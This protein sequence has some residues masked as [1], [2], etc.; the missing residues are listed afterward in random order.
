[1]TC[2]TFL[3]C[4]KHLL[5]WS[6]QL[7]QLTKEVP[8]SLCRVLFVNVT[9]QVIQ[10]FPLPLGTTNSGICSFSTVFSIALHLKTIVNPRFSNTRSPPEMKFPDHSYGTAK[11]TGGYNIDEVNYSLPGATN[12]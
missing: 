8:L 1:M 12:R 4:G 2:H 6:F 5:P 10:I 11:G 7:V 3:S 9:I